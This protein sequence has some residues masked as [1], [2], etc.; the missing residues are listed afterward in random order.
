VSKHTPGPWYAQRTNWKGEP[1]GHKIYI[2]GDEHETYDDEDDEDA[3]TGVAIVEGNATSTGV[4]EA[5]ARL[6]AAAPDLY[7][8]C[9]ALL[10]TGTHLGA[11]IAMAQAAVAKAEGGAR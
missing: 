6:I 10:D 1:A 4:T 5:N 9:E 3:A 11:V 7:A 8:A 2:L